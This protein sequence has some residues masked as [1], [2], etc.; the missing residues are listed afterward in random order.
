MA[1]EYHAGPMAARRAISRDEGT[2]LALYSLLVDRSVSSNLDIVLPV[3]A[4]DE[5]AF[6]RGHR[7]VKLGGHG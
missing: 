1:S 4:C 3:A 5:I 7:V 6:E 2:N